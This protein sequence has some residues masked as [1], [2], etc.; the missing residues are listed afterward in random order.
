MKFCKTKMNC[1]NSE[2]IEKINEMSVFVVHTTM[3]PCHS[4]T[5]SCPEFKGF[6]LNT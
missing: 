4:V 6:G 5:P 2:K 3:K 1:V